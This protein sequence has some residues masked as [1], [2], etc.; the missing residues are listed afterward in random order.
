VKRLFVF[1]AIVTGTFA[2]TV[3]TVGADVVSSPL[4]SGDACQDFSGLQSNPAGRVTVMSDRSSQDVT[5]R[6]HLRDLVPSRGYYV[7]LAE[8]NTQDGT[9]IGCAANVQG[10]LADSRGHLDDTLSFTLPSGS[11]TIQIIVNEAGQFTETP[12][13]V[14]SQDTLVV[15]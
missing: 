11:H 7:W 12:V 8:V 10:A 6:L 1:I 13:A 2:L 3:G 15:P 5:V 4:G 14:S 9:P